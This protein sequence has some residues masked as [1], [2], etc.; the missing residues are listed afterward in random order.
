MAT[1]PIFPTILLGRRDDIVEP[2]TVSASDNS[3]D[4]LIA[5][6]AGTIAFYLSYN[7]ILGPLFGVVSMTTQV[8][9][10]AVTAF[11]IV[12]T[13]FSQDGSMG[14]VAGR[15]TMTD[16]QQQIQDNGY[17]NQWRRFAQF[18]GIYSLE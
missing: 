6:A 10:C 3:N 18:S 17:R 14:R 16:A 9:I 11:F 12:Y 13:F 7:Y 1:Q 4:L 5:G 15:D 2:M 8:A